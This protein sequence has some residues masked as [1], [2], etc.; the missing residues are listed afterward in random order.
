MNYTKQVRD[1]CRKNQNKFI[2]LSVVKNEFADIPYKTLLK[3]FN[4]LEEEGLVQAISKGVYSTCNRNINEKTVLKEY[5][6]KG[7]GMIVGYSLFNYIGLTG[8]QDD[9]VEI[10]TNAITSK[11][12]TIGYFLLKK[13]DLMFTDGIVDLISLLEILDVGFGMKGGDFITYK[14]TVELLVQSYNDENFKKANKAIHYK[15]S[16]IQKLID[17]L[18]R[19]KIENSCLQMYQI[20]DI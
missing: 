12:K 15:Y 16:T 7:K 8:Y 1:Y 10:Y 14:N 18:G 5:T 20:D 11:Q 9:K 6:A 17:L 2:D 3:I 4:R 13:V 19:L